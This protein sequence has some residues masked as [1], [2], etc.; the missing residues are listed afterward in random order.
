MAA[1]LREASKRIRL[2]E[3]VDEVLRRAVAICPR[4]TVG[5]MV[6]PLVRALAATAPNQ[7]AG[8]G[9]RPITDELAD[10]VSTPARTGSGDCTHFREKILRG[11]GSAPK[12]RRRDELI[13]D[14]PLR[15]PGG[16]ASASQAWSL[17]MLVIE[18]PISVGLPDPHQTPRGQSV[19]RTRGR[20]D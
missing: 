15:G 16:R 14:P 1:E 10:V 3:Q 18:G 17:L 9:W 8:R 6:F 20:F 4:G 13:D 11:A 12:T 7:G 2:L 5:K 19:P